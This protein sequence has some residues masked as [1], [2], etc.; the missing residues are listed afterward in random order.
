M[1]PGLPLLLL[2]GFLGVQV[3]CGADNLDKQSPAVVYGGLPLVFEAN[4]GQADPR[5]RF[6]ARGHGY[7]LFLA[8]KEVVLVIGAADPSS[9]ASPTGRGQAPHSRAAVVRMR[10][11]GASASAAVEGGEPLPGTSSYFIGRDAGQWRRHVPTYAR[12]KC[13]NVYP[14]I[15]LV[16][17]GNRGRLEYD[18]IVGPGADPGA[19]RFAITGAQRL[20]V[21]KA[22][23]LILT[24]GAG[25]LRFHKPIIYQVSTTG[26]R[27]ITGGY[28]L[29]GGRQVAFEIASYDVRTPLF[30]DPVISYSTYFG[31]SNSDAGYRI[32]V[33]SSGYAYIAGV[34]NSLDYP[35]AQ[36]F[37]P[38]HGGSMD[39][40]VAKLNPA[41]TA[42]LYSTYLGGKQA[43]LVSGIGVD[44]SGS[45]YVTGS[46]ESPD[47]PTTPGAYR[48]SGSGFVTKLSARGD[49]LAWS[50]LLPAVQPA[51]IAVDH[52]GNTYVT[53][54]TSSTGLPVTA[55]AFQGALAGAGDAFIA[56][57]NATGSALSYCTYLGGSGSDVGR[58]IAVDS[59]GSAYI[60]GSTDS[61]DFRT[62]NAFQ[63]GYRGSAIYRS[64]NA[65]NWP[66]MNDGLASRAVWALAVDPRNPSVIY[67]GSDEGPLFRTTTGGSSWTAIELRPAPTG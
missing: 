19:V 23:E 46:T 28:R 58:A 59:S 4:H 16:Y 63:S 24:T 40:F 52:A 41:G 20:A 30:I 32:A 65:G 25:E 44:P 47:F 57:V 62:A 39:V 66:A 55:G 33:D 7:A 50:T 15:D 61:R 64:T 54:S 60:T 17:Y 14:G 22:G 51:G 21:N 2:A 10:F 9:K 13:R 42:T 35:M 5:A 37:Q 6:V 8:A 49:A 18:L 36:A 38:S 53:G 11:L 12:V 67:A 34:T 48:A 27:Q 43:D 31:G 26:R 1:G 45:V 56:K 29:L 3:A